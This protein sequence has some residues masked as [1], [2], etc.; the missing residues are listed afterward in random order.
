MANQRDMRHSGEVDQAKVVSKLMLGFRR[1]FGTQGKTPMNCSN[2]VLD[3]AI[4]L[5][6]KADRDLKAARPRSRRATETGS[7]N[8]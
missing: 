1:L 7:G 4:G 3:E 5:V 2:E 8:P 6:F